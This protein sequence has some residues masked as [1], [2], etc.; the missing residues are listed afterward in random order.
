MKRCPSIAS[1]N[2]NGRR[3]PLHLKVVE[4]SGRRATS[5][6]STCLSG[7]DPEA[8]ADYRELAAL[9]ACE[10]LRETPR[11]AGL[12]G[13]Q[14][15]GKT[16]LGNLI[17]AACASV[18]IR[19]CLL[20]LDDFYLPRK[21]RLAFARRVHPLFE[22]RGAPGT[23]DTD[24]CREA[25]R[26]LRGNAEVDLP[27]FDKGLDDRFGSRRVRGA[28]DVV[29]LEGWCVGAEPESD[30]DLA[31][32]INAL[33]EVSDVQ[34]VWR[35]SVNESLG[36][37]YGSIF[38]DLDYLV[39]LRVPDLAAVRD[40]RLQQEDSLPV[41]RRQSAG[42]IDRFV[43]HYERLTLSMMRTLPARADLVVGLSTDHS[44]ATMFFRSP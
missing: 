43:Q 6:L 24:L 37:A 33:E 29:L 35:R 44:I 9:I 26:Q 18:G 27:V 11:F 38:S 25:I 3:D 41:A 19:V 13:G 40:W 1:Q 20:G 42:E 30:D 15:A 21:D 14:G 5:E 17:V 2:R 12:A 16:T 7:L 22:T 32:P 34:S 36:G 23:H 28:F 39:Y 31:V 10:W 4:L 8:P